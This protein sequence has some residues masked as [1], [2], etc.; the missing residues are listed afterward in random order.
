MWLVLIFGLCLLLCNVFITLLTHYDIFLASI[1]S[2]LVVDH[3]VYFINCCLKAEQVCHTLQNLIDVT[4]L[5][6]LNFKTHL[7]V[8]FP[9]IVALFYL[10][11]L[12]KL[13]IYG[14][15]NDEVLIFLHVFAFYQPNFSIW[16]T[17][18]RRVSLF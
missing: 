17:F 16:L 6:L 7:I 14:S 4:Y 18:I 15:L 1:W 9:L 2:N 11:S 3:K 5:L 12:H 8:V 10:A 13:R